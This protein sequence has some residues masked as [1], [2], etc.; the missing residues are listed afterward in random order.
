MDEDAIGGVCC[1]LLDDYFDYNLLQ[2]S[3]T[4]LFMSGKPKNSGTLLFF[5]HFIFEHKHK[6]ASCDVVIM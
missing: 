1:L 2:S 4:L 5:P 6:T 3:G